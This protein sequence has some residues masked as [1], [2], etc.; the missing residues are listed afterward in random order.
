M[1]PLQ[2]GNEL[3]FQ[4]SSM[5]NQ[6][7]HKSDQAMILQQ[8]AP[9]SLDTGL[10]YTNIIMGRKS[11]RDIETSADRNN[12]DEDHE[13]RIMHREIERQRRQEMSNLYS[14]LRSVLPL[15]YIKGKRSICDQMNEAANYIKHLEKKVKELNHK[16]DE[17]KRISNSRAQIC[18]VDGSSSANC[19]ISVYPCLGGVRILLKKGFEDEKSPLSRV[20]QLL[21]EEGLCVVSCVSTRVDETLL[22]EIH[23]ELPQD[24]DVKH[25][26]LHALQQKLLNLNSTSDGLT[27]TTTQTFYPDFLSQKLGVGNGLTSAAVGN[28]RQWAK[29]LSS[30]LA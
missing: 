17:L 3:C 10:S 19:A 20:L 18:S 4:I 5:S 2:Q 23:S 9:A 21:L 6:Q 7:Q 8:Y 25:F 11:R 13:K 14:S 1:F 12:D 27:S 15:D 22:H 28:L 24:G 26:D 16:R 29:A 30:N